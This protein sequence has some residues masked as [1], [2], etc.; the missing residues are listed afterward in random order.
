LIDASSILG[1][2]EVDSLRST[3][4]FNEIGTFNPHLKAAS[5]VHPHSEHIRIARTA[6]ITT[7]LARP[8]GGRIFGQSA[9]IHL[10][11]WTTPDMLVVDAFGLHMSVPS[12]P[13]HLPEDKEA[14]KKQIDEHKKALKR[15]EDYIAKA[16][17]YADVKQ[18][19]ATDPKIRF[20]VDLT[21]EA[22]VPYV[23]G[24]NPVIFEAGTY[25]P[26]L[27]AIEFAEK[28]K[29]KCILGGGAESWKLADVL[30]QKGIPVILATVLSYPRGEFE[31]WDSVYRCAAELDRAG[32]RFCFGSES[33]SSAFDLGSMVGMAVAH[34]LL[35]ERAEYALTLGAAEILGI[36]DRVGSIE[37][38]KRADLIVTTDT[39]LQT[40]AQV[41]HMF[42]DGRPID[43]R[44]MQTESYEKFKNRPAPKL[45]PMPELRGPKSLTAR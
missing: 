13:A 37:P 9:V 20:D 29:L 41:T 8:S 12:L 44:S 38:G 19:A 28:H 7:A 25:K 34:G 23:R 21:L 30:K 31:A 32:V 14:K 36:A 27:D 6:G 17:H 3:R 4:D 42:I 10:D 45:S 24:E 11:G 2:N 5:A 1:L 26:I 39:P 35:R 16:K 22:M 18:L 33:A 15:L 43:L 40:V